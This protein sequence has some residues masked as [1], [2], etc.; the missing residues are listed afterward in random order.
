M[1]RLGACYFRH[2]GRTH[3]TLCVSSLLLSLPSSSQSACCDGGESEGDEI[4]H[5]VGYDGIA[6]LCK[7]E[8]PISTNPSLSVSISAGLDPSRENS[9][10][11]SSR[12]G[13]HVP[14]LYVYGHC[15]VVPYMQSDLGA[16]HS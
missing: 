3:S 6:E 9:E 1:Q 7:F 12:S 10:T 13:E 14:F 16:Q 15:P 8:D 4:Q 5:F 11:W 2:G